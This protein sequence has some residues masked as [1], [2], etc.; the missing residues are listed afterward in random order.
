M[1]N[2]CETNNDH[3]HQMR[4]LKHLFSFANTEY[5]KLPVQLCSTL[6]AFPRALCMYLG[7]GTQTTFEIVSMFN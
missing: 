7:F 1:T 5:S 3:E 2:S 4:K 6:Q